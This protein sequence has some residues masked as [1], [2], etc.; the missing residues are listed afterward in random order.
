MWKTHLSFTSTFR[1]LGRNYSGRYLIYGLNQRFVINVF[2]DLLQ[3]NEVN[4]FLIQE[5]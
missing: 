1:R 5:S 4:I 3:N 2:S